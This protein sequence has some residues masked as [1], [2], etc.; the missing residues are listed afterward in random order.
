MLVRIGR[1]NSRG[2]KGTYDNI[3]H[4]GEGCRYAVDV[5]SAAAEHFPF[6]EWIQGHNVHTFLTHDGRK[7]KFRPLHVGRE[8]GDDVSKGYVGLELVEVLPGIGRAVLM[9]V[10]TPEDVALCIQ[11]M[12][13]WARPR[14]VNHHRQ[15]GNDE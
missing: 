15:A 14:H 3:D 9:Q 2:L 7:Y 10:I 6:K 4:H 5:L 1:S 12:H 8:P 13:H 11:M